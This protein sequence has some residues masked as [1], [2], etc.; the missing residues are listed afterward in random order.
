MIFDSAIFVTR[1]RQL[2]LDVL[3]NVFELNEKEYSEREKTQHN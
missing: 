1:E 3:R 2:R